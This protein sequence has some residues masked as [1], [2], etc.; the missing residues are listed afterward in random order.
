MKERKARKSYKTLYLHEQQRHGHTKDRLDALR[1][2]L[3]EVN[4]AIAPYGRSTLE[5]LPA[6]EGP[7]TLDDMRFVSARAFMESTLQYYREDDVS[8]ALGH[9]LYTWRGRPIVRSQQK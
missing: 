7:V 2:R 4:A 6:S 1:R 9:E 5:T 8:Q 3:D